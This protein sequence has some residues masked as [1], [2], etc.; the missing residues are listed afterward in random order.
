MRPYDG[1][2]QAQQDTLLGRIDGYAGPLASINANINS[3]GLE[4]KVVSGTLTYEQTRF[5]F[6]NTERGRKLAEDISASL[7]EMEEDGTLA[8]LSEKYFG[9]DLTVPGENF[10]V[11]D[12]AELSIPGGEG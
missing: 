11:P 6:A 8:E 9:E 10:T 7:E 4:L 12:P 3:K 5:P 2:A 1:P